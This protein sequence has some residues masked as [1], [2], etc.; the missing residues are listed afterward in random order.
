MRTLALLAATAGVTLALAPTAFAAQDPIPIGP[1]QYFQGQVKGLH[2]SA[3]IDVVCP[4]PVTP[5][6]QGH[7]VAGQNVQV[8]LGASSTTAGY[9][10]SLGRSVVADFSPAISSGLP[11]RL[12]FTSYYAPQEIPTS[13]WLPC[14]GTVK[15]PFVPQPT[16]P[17]AITDYVVV[18]YVNIAV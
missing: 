1:N 11:Q 18:T 14:F 4:G 8:V 6:R 5:N 15:V 2:A 10:G 9:T 3:E 12:T 16:G 17:T 7:P 13:Y